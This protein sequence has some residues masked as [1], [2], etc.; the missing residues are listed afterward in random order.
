MN[1]QIYQFSF[2][3]NKKQKKVLTRKMDESKDEEEIPKFQKMCR[4]DYKNPSFF[5]QRDT[6]VKSS[7]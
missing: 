3:Q 1:N 6:D 2:Q 7:K 5:W 4:Y